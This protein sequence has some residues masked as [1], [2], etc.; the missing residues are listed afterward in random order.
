[1]ASNFMNF[2]DKVHN[3]LSAISVLHS[4]KPER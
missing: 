3:M 1:M 2:F 4:S